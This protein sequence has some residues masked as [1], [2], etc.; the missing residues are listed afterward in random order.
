MLSWKGHRRRSYCL[1]LLLRHLF[2]I[3]LHCYLIYT[4][5]LGLNH[6]LTLTRI[7]MLH[8]APE[9]HLASEY[10]VVLENQFE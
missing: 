9:K 1:L 2:F 4:T 10:K 7:N 6:I 3:C 8:F 5:Y